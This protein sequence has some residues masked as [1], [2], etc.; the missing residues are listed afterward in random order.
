MVANSIYHN[1]NRKKQPFIKIN[2]ASLPDHLLESELFGYEPGAFTD[3]KK[4]KLGKFELAHSGTLFLDE[5][6]DMPILMQAKLLR[7]LEEKKVERLGGNRIIETDFRLISATNQNLEQLIEHGKFRQDLYYRL[8]MIQIQLPS[9]RELADDIPR[10]CQFFLGKFSQEQN[11]R[12][13]QIHPI[14]KEK[15][16]QY[17]WPGNIREL[18]NVINRAFV[19]SDGKQILPENLPSSITGDKIKPI[20]KFSHVIP[21]DDLEK[22]HIFN[23]LKLTKGNKNRTASILNIHRDTLYRKIKKYNIEV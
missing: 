9:L 1:S 12:T 13:P 8:N 10:L 2:C 19:L 23:I 17:F 6:G 5:I 7:V 22:E 20:N 15:L 21:L 18:K 14:T 16:L 3:A 4:L 11:K